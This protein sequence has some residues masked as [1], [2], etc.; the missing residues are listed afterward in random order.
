MST[1]LQTVKSVHGDKAALVDKLLPLADRH[2][3]ETE[4]EFKERLLRI[5]NQKLLRMLDRVEDVKA[6]FGSREALV[7]KIVAFE[8]AGKGDADRRQKLLTLS[9]G[10]LV[11]LHDVLAKRA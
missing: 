11:D 2:S 6:R 5:S 1:P 7:D 8:T 10:R 3:D 4:A 9:I